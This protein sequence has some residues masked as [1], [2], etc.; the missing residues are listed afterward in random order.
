MDVN[1]RESLIVFRII[2]EIAIVISII[3]TAGWM[4]ALYLALYVLIPPFKRLWHWI[5]FWWG[6]V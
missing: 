2:L 5:W 3:G 4:G 1:D 6:L